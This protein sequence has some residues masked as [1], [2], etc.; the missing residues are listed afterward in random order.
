MYEKI[1]F[2]IGHLMLDLKKE[3][4]SQKAHTKTIILFAIK[5]G[6]KRLTPKGKES[7]N[8]VRHKEEKKKKTISQNIFTLL[9]TRKS[10]I[11]QGRSQND[12]ILII[13]V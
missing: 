2:K 8:Y 1:I 12:V 13:Y 5:K 7:N 10:C 11:T 9:Y 4:K 6:K 3:K